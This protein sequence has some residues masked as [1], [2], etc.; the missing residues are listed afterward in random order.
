MATDARAMQRILKIFFI[1][2]VFVFIIFV[3]ITLLRNYV[4]TIPFPLLT[5][6]CQSPDFFYIIN[7]PYSLQQVF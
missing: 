1:M 3:V 7:L 2:Y 6:H 5:F 4:I